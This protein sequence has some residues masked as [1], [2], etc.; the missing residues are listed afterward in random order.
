MAIDC[1]LKCSKGVLISFNL[2]FWMSGCVFLVLGIWVILDPTK[3]HIFHL[4]ATDGVPLDFVLYLAYFLIVIGCVIIFGGFCGCCGSLYER[5]SLLIAYFVFLFLLLCAELAVAIVTLVYREEFLK[6]LEGRLMNRFKEHY[7]QD[8]N[9][10][11]QAIDQAQFRFN[12]CGILSDN[13]Y[14]TTKWKNES[15][16]ISNRSRVNV[17]VTCC[18]LANPDV[19]ESWQH[20]QAK[21][22]TACQ[23]TEYERHR[24]ARHKKGCLEDLKT[25][26]K[27]DTMI[28][29]GLGIGIA[30]LHI[31][32][33]IFSISLCRNLGDARR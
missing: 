28:L 10:F 16:G 17:P 22:E 32:G 2:F 15:V 12:C 25:W 9:I 26:F 20:P 31:L 33:M 13:D 6:G 30:F 27:E 14:A 21:D 23:D 8:S 29:I 3:T 18:I 11:T 1:S 19:E 5:R 24:L 7:G 4:T